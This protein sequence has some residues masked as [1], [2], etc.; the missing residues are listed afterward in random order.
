MRNRMNRWLAAISRHGWHAALALSAGLAVLVGLAGIML[1]RLSPGLDQ[2]TRASTADYC[3]LVSCSG[4]I[5]ATLA[6][7]PRQ[8]ATLKPGSGRISAARTHKTP[9]SAAQL[10]RPLPSTVPAPASQLAPATP[11]SA[12]EGQ[13]CG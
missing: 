6:P 9:S 2:P 1:A 7:D 13:S 4:D 8:D 5:S 12:G 10:S 11:R 3:E